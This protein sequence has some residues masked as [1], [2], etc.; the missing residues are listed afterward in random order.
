[1][2]TKSIK[3]DLVRPTKTARKRYF[4]VQTNIFDSVWQ[5][6]KLE[7]GQIRIARIES[8]V[9]KRSG[10]ELQTVQR[11]SP[12]QLTSRIPPNIKVRK[13]SSFVTT[14]LTLHHTPGTQWQHTTSVS[15]NNWTAMNFFSGPSAFVH[16]YLVLSHYHII[17]YSSAFLVHAY[18]L[19]FRTFYFPALFT[20]PLF[21]RPPLEG[22]MNQCC[23]ISSVKSMEWTVV[24]IVRSQWSLSR[25]RR[26]QPRHDLSTSMT[27]IKR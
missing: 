27:E 3:H 9:L 24:F 26:T 4:T 16:T 15:L 20:F 8:D 10:A 18:S 13:K 25:R 21:P 12:E 7:Q 5:A 17:N 23:T 14:T 11:S 19:C 2:K 1:M 22:S 6:E